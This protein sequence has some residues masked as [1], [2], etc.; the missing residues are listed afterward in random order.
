L[1]VDCCPVGQYRQGHFCCWALLRGD[2]HHHLEWI[3]NEVA[4]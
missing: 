2:S 3:V 1:I 4:A